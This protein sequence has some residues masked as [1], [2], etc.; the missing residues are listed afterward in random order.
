MPDQNALVRTAIAR[1]LSERTGVAVISM[2]ES[3]AEL[4]AAAGAALTIDRLQDL[5]LEMAEVRGMMVALD[6]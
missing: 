6:L 3:I 2:K 4:P 5:L 1:L